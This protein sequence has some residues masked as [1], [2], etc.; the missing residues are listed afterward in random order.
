[1]KKQTTLIFIS[2]PFFSCATIKYKKQGFVLKEDFI[3]EV[4]FDYINDLIFIPVT[5]DNKKYN[6]L[7]D[8]GAELNIFDPLIVDSLNL[9]KLKKGTISNGKNSNSGIQRVEINNIEIGGVQ[10]FETVGMVWDMTKVANLVGCVKIDGII[11]NNLM[12]KAI[13]QIDYKNKKIKISD[14]VA[15]FH[16]SDNAKKTVMH[17][18]NYGNVFLNVQINDKIKKF[19]FDTGFNGFMQTGDTAYLRN[20]SYITTI[21]LTGGDYSGKKEGET[22]FRYLESFAVN[23]LE[24]KSPSLFLIKPNNSSILGNEFYKNFTLTIDW[25]NDLLLFDTQKDIEFKSPDLFEMSLY[26]DY[27]ENEILISSINKESSLLGQ[28]KPHTKVLYI[29]DYDVSS[30]RKEELCAFWVNEWLDLKKLEKLNLTV[31]TEG[32]TKKLIVEKIKKVW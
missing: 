21:G 14:K 32:S 2:L 31:E 30:F 29:N 24:F 20:K 5:I 17:S 18:G 25:K 22:Y 9:K 23:N 1:M 4:S 15:N 27:G 19:T 11:S 3:N 16:I 10:F 6:F 8:T 7:F 13:W 28:I 12:R 26:P